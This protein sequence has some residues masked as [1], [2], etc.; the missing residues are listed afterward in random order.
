MK[1]MYFA[2]GLLLSTWFFGVH[3][4][5]FRIFRKGYLSPQEK[6]EFVERF[7][8]DLFDKIL[9]LKRDP[10]MSNQKWKEWLSVCR[11]SDQLLW[12]V[13]PRTR[14]T[15]LEKMVREIMND[16]EEVKS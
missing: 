13:L 8:N 4:R 16:S 11:Y 9:G 12:Q 3:H 5:I 7:H 15:S 1:A 6:T 2:S 10:F 14:L